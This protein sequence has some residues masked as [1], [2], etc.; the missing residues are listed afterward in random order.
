[1][2][3]EKQKKN[4]TVALENLFYEVWIIIRAM[5]KPTFSRRKNFS[6]FSNSCKFIQYADKNST[7]SEYAMP[8]I[9]NTIVHQKFVL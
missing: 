6:D 8:D 9:L 1:M 3:H 5:E 4:E 2:C 7:F